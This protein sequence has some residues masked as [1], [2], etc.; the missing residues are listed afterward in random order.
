MMSEY[1]QRISILNQSLQIFK[2]SAQSCNI[3]DMLEN[4]MQFIET[5]KRADDLY[6]KLPPHE[7]KDEKETF[8]RSKIL[9]QQYFNIKGSAARKCKCTS[10]L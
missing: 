3:I 5:L 9:V 10:S 8:N 1:R 4:N 6:M 2:N 7:K